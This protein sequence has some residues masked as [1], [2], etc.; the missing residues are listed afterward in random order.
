[1]QLYFVLYPTNRQQNGLTYSKEDIIMEFCAENILGDL[2]GIFDP[3]FVKKVDHYEDPYLVFRINQKDEEIKVSPFNCGNRGWFQNKFSQLVWRYFTG[4]EHCTAEMRRKLLPFA[5]L[6]M[7][8]ESITTL[9]EQAQMAFSTDVRGGGF[10]LSEK[11]FG[12]ELW[13][14]ELRNVAQFE[15]PVDFVMKNWGR[16]SFFSQEERLNS[17]IKGVEAVLGVKAVKNN[18]MDFGGGGQM[19]LWVIPDKL[20]NWWADANNAAVSTVNGLICESLT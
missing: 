12:R 17:F 10:L 9:L 3:K 8:C 18:A 1:M 4:E 7:A 6:K 14:L 2:F 20:P 11:C 5:G 19:F 15:T 13:R 16:N